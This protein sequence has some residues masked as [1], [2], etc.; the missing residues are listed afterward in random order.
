MEFVYGTETFILILLYKFVLLL[1][2]LPLHIIVVIIM[3]TAD[4][5]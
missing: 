1:N 3:T 5:P 2:I 4:F